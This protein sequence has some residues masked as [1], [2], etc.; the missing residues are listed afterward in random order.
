VRFSSL[1]L[2]N[3]VIDNQNVVNRLSNKCEFLNSSF[4]RLPGTPSVRRNIFTF[5]PFSVATPVLPQGQYTLNLKSS[6]RNTRGRLL[7][8]GTPHSP[9]PSSV[10][11]DAYP[12]VSRKINPMMGQPGIDLQKEIVATFT[13][14]LAL[15]SLSGTLFPQDASTNPP[16]IGRPHV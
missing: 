6:I 14:P 11:T 1:L 4:A 12:P 5:D 13:Q 9:P 8:N 7:N 10:G 3:D 16:T 15:S 2:T